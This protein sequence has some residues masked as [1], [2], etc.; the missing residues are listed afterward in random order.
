MR[1][2]CHFKGNKT[3]HFELLKAEHSIKETSCLR[4]KCQRKAEVAKGM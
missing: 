2:T 3:P 4:D 1:T